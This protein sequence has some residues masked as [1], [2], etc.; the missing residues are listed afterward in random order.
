M[1]IGD[2]FDLNGNYPFVCQSEEIINNDKAF[3]CCNYNFDNDIC[4]EPI[5]VGNPTNIDTSDSTHNSD[6]TNENSIG[7]SSYGSTSKKSSGI[8]KGVIIGAVIGGIAVIGIIITIIV[9]C[10]KKGKLCHSPE[11]DS[12][13]EPGDNTTKTD[14]PLKGDPPSEMDNIAKTNPSSKND[15]PSVIINN[16]KK[17]ENEPDETFQFGTKGKND[18]DIIFITTSQ[19]KTRIII[20]PKKSIKELIRFYLVKEQKPE[21]FGDSRIRFVKNA[22]TL[23][24]NSDDLIEKYNNTK[25]YSKFIIMVDYVE[26]NNDPDSTINN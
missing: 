18:I 21:L 8:S 26:E 25:I 11:N 13:S 5:N 23:P 12:P 3:N 10:Y 19:K 22:T 17:A 20:D 16:M 14:K 15:S 7:Y 2:I 9:V 6:S 4:D 1:E 24:H